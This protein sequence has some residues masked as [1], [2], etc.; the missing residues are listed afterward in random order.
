MATYEAALARESWR[1]LFHVLCHPSEFPSYCRESVA[2][3]RAYY[4]AEDVVDMNKRDIVELLAW[5]RRTAMKMLAAMV[6]LI[7]LVALLVASI[8]RDKYRKGS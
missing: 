2:Q 7:V 5:T 1:R 8:C 3:N 4:R 6:F